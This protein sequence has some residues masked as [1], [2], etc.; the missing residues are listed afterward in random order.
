[1]ENFYF[2]WF[3]TKYINVYLKIV[4]KNTVFNLEVKSTSPI[5]EQIVSNAA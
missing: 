4:F 1:M 2:N 3:N 5:I